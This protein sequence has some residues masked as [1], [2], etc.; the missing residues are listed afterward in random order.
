VRL[1]YQGSKFVEDLFGLCASDPT[2]IPFV[3]QALR[4]AQYVS[5]AT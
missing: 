5:A 1:A 4:A 3:N 2:T